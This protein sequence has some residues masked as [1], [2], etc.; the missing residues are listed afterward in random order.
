MSP[1]PLLPALSITE[2]FTSPCFYPRPCQMSPL[3]GAIFHAFVFNQ[4]PQISTVYQIPRLHCTRFHKARLFYNLYGACRTLIAII[5]FIE[6]G[7]RLIHA[8][9]FTITA[10][11]RILFTIAKQLQA[12]SRSHVDDNRLLWSL[13]FLSWRRN[14]NYIRVSRCQ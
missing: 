7:T 3:H 6:D 11:D 4:G 5:T 12:S 9:L 10:L 1:S 13:R 14:F 8:V 2:Q